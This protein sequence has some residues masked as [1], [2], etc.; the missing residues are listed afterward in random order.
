MP[1]T[2]D[3]LRRKITGDASRDEGIGSLEGQTLEITLTALYALNAKEM[4]SVS[5]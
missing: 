1:M 2:V 3:L 4:E 5:Y